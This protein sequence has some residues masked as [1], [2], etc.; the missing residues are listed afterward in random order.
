MAQSRFSG[1]SAGELT[2][3]A[4]MAAAAEELAAGSEAATLPERDLE[5]QAWVTGEPVE[6]PEPEPESDEFLAEIRDRVV[7]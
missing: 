3:I 5:P 2:S 7:P 6:T 4:A 1:E